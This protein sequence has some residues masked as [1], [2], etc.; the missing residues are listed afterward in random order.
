MFG[1]NDHPRDWESR[2]PLSDGDLIAHLATT[3]PPAVE[4]VRLFRDRHMPSLFRY[5][6]Q[7]APEERYANHLAWQAI[8]IT[9]TSAAAGRFRPRAV[10][11][12][13][14]LLV[15]ELAAE[16]A[17]DEREQRLHPGFLRWLTSFGGDPR[18]AVPEWAR[19]SV[20]VQALRR[21]PQHEQE[22]LWYVEIEGSSP[23][24]AGLHAGT[25]VDEF[26]YQHEH[27]LLT[28]G[29]NY[30]QAYREIG[31]LSPECR[32][33]VRIM[34]TAARRSQ[35]E[36]SPE[37]SAHRR[38]CAR[39]EDAVRELEALYHHPGPALISALLGYGLRTYSEASG[40]RA[41]NPRSSAE[42][43]PESPG[44][45]GHSWRR[46]GHRGNRRR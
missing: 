7:C 29:R 28:L 44:P 10:R 45:R 17:A 27:A 23:E 14:L 36:I 41:R 43:P 1:E 15:Q 24:L 6:W 26:D 35:L 9:E 31:G 40:S 13:M 4:A 38:S 33:Y 11:H 16:W 30:L 25:A 46:L 8:S 19:R 22:L 37:F 34:D 42:N 12:G 20:M 3:E 18:L 5:A 21:A 2:L 39:C 32:G